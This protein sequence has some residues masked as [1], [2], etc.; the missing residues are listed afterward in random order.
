[1]SSSPAFTGASGAGSR[2]GAVGTAD[3]ARRY[4][5]GPRW[6]RS[7][8]ADATGTFGTSLNGCPRRTTPRWT[9]SSTD[10]RWRSP[11]M[12]LLFKLAIGIFLGGTR[13]RVWRNILGL[14]S[15]KCL[16]V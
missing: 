10:D 12:V 14:L 3:A 11:Q 9:G 5:I 6:E 2:S 16:S 1:M 13:S 8:F 4:S 7:G 15:R